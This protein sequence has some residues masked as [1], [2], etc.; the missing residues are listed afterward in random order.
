VFVPNK[1]VGLVGEWPS[2]NPHHTSV[3]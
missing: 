1:R 2:G 3:C